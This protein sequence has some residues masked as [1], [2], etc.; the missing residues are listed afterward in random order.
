M[1]KVVCN[2]CKE[3]LR[4]TGALIFNPPDDEGGCKKYHICRECWAHSET[5]LNKTMR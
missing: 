5:L 2:Q 4:E 3:E 1:I